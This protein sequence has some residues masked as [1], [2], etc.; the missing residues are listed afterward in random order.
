MRALWRRWSARYGF[1]GA[2]RQCRRCPG[3]LGGLIGVI[4]DEAGAVVPG[5]T[6]TVTYR[7]ATARTF[8]GR[9]PAIWC[10]LGYLVDSSPPYMLWYGDGPIFGDL[11][12][13]G[14]AIRV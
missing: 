4:R 2:I 7:P 5:A 12:R 10:Q 3:Q 9:L 8:A 6:V 11:G 13:L 1:V 14:S